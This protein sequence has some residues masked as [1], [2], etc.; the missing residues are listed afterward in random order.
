[1]T[2]LIDLP[3]RHNWVTD[4]EGRW[5]PMP[6]PVDQAMVDALR[7]GFEGRDDDIIGVT[8]PKSGTAWLRQ[9]L[10]I[11]LDDSDGVDVRVPYIEGTHLTEMPDPAAHV[12]TLERRADP[13]T[14]VSHLPLNMMTDVTNRRGRYVC[15]ARHPKD[16]A[17]SMHYFL[18]NLMGREQAPTWPD[19]LDLY[20]EGRVYYG[21]IFD[22]VL[23]WWRASQ[24]SDRVHFMTYSGLKRDPLAEVTRLAAFIG[25]STTPETIAST[26]ERSSFSSMRRDDLSV[27]KHTAPFHLRKGVVGDWRNHFTHAQN[28]VFD[29]R[30]RAAWEGSDLEPMFP[31]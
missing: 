10:R 7:E 30:C 19:F 18:S 13:R 16:C 23:D 11:L 28:A 26:V 21:S 3:F 24:A 9:L 2:K 8:Y 6:R 15:L 4:G 31:L 20:L 1:M 22:H 25:A 17:V 27:V 12:A 14:L 5:M 29:A